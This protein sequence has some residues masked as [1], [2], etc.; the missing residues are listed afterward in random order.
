M[1][2]TFDEGIYTDSELYID[3]GTFMDVLEGLIP[4]DKAN[5]SGSGETP[6][7]LKY[8]SYVFL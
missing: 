4:A 6:S 1:S 7:I 2:L 3:G 8:V 5:A